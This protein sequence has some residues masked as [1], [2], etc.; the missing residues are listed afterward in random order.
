MSKT[1]VDY[2]ETSKIAAK[3]EEISKKII[4]I[5]TDE[6]EKFDETYTVG[7]VSTLLICTLGESTAFLCCMLEGYLSDIG[8]IHPTATEISSQIYKTANRFIEIKKNKEE[9]CYDYC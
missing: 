1:K 6:I 7:E 5:I 9:K 3:L 4:D 2:S 8:G